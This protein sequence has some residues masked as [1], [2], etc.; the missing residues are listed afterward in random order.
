MS[1]CSAIIPRVATCPSSLPRAQ[2]KSRS[3]DLTDCRIEDCER[4][5]DRRRF[6]HNALGSM[7]DAWG[8]RYFQVLKFS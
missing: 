3:D 7:E 4:P 6:L 5:I 8:Y 1:M 2:V